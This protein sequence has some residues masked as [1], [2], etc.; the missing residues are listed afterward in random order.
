MNLD[1]INAHLN[2][3]VTT[4]T[5]IAG[6]GGSLFTAWKTLE[7][8]IIVPAR[9]LMAEHKDK[10]AKLEKIYAEVTPKGGGSIKDTIGAIKT[11]LARIENWHKASMS[12]DE[13]GLYETDARGACV[14]A[15]RAFLRLVDATEEQV[16][17]FG[18]KNFIHA[19]DQDRFF[20][21]FDAAIKDGRDF[22]SHFRYVDSNANFIKVTMEAVSIKG[23]DGKADSYIVR[24]VKD[25]P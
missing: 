3:I 15:N 24:I 20:K 18:W 2:S 13:N 25:I 1:F 7:K 14:W 10:M 22:K 5:V 8:F 23:K 11:K 4:L 9:N 6:I 17:G 16:E 12:L 19:E 21:Q